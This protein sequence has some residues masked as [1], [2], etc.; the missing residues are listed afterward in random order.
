MHICCCFRW[1]RPLRSLLP[2]FCIP[3]PKTQT[4]RHHPP[5]LAGQWGLY[6]IWFHLIVGL[7]TISFAFFWTSLVVALIAYVFMFIIAYYFSWN[8][9]KPNYPDNRYL[10]TSLWF[11]VGC[12]EIAGFGMRGYIITSAW[13]WK[14]VLL[15]VIWVWGLEKSI[16]NSRSPFNFFVITFNLIPKTELWPNFVVLQL[17]ALTYQSINHSTPPIVLTV[18]IIYRFLFCT[19]YTHWYLTTMPIRNE[20]VK[21]EKENRKCRLGRAS[22]N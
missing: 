1:V 5:S 14:Q 10:I 7:F 6:L 12:Y 17:M 15:S 9:F 20:C 3:A 8:R 4:H 2:C 21:L 16:P 22:N 11:M 18:D 19:L 13:K